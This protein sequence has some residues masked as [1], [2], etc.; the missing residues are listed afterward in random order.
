MH[1]WAHAC[2]CVLHA[3]P[4]GPAGPV[5][6]VFSWVGCFLGVGCCMAPPGCCGVAS[7]CWVAA[8]ATAACVSM[9]MDGCLLLSIGCA[10]RE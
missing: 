1:A 7:P 2:M 10:A 8:A 3:A 5:G 9:A 6:W 4:P